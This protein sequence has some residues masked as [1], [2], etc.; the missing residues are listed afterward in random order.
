MKALPSGFQ[1]HLESA[2]TTLCW[3]W[4]L[5]RSDGLRLGFTDHDRN[6]SFDDV[7]FEAESGFAAGEIVDSAGL[8]IANLE[9]SGALTSAKLDE[10][11]LAAGRFDDASIEI[12]RVNWSDV[13][14]RVLMR[15]GSL[16]EVRRSSSAF[17]AE[18]RG[19]A[20]FLGQEN[21]RLYQY[22]CDAELGDARCRIN[23]A[24][25]G[26]KGVGQ[27]TGANALWAFEASG[28]DDFAAGFFDGGLLA[29]TTGANQGGQI[30]VKRHMPSPNGATLDLWRS[31]ARPIAPGD[32]FTVTAGCNKLFST[33]RARF[34]NAFNFRGFPHIPGN[35]FLLNAAACANGATDG[36][37][38]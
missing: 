20:H 18:A 12:W 17:I 23:L 1:A 9:V 29:W 21:G 35:D 36:S 7:V 16:G 25:S 22:S 38:L 26:W 6:L 32:A 33:C 8:N 27:V 30:E 10:A 15:K 3:C 28:L 24:A 14:Q 34:A 5:E 4:K 2:T 37:A 13:S 19:L 11:S 31:M